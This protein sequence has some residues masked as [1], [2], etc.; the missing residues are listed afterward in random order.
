MDERLTL[1]ILAWTVGFV[2]AG[3]FVMD[4][5]ALASVH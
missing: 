2:V 4:A 1:T 3:A 5:L